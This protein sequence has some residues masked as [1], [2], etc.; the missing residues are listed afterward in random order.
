MVRRIINLRVLIDADEEFDLDDLILC[1]R[2]ERSLALLDPDLIP[3][4]EVYLP[5]TNYC[6]IVDYLHVYEEEP[7]GYD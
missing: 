3:E 4:H 2:E 7:G 6:E 5:A 1:I